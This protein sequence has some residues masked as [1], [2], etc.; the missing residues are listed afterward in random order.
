MTASFH[1]FFFF[2]NRKGH[3]WKLADKRIE[4][5]KCWIKTG[6]KFH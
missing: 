4:Q 3:H 6:E 1:F 2:Q 5:Q